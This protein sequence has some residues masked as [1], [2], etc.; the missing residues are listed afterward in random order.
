MDPSTGQKSDTGGI[1]TVLQERSTSLTSK[2]T[3][4]NDEIKQATGFKKLA[5]EANVAQ[6][7]GFFQPYSTPSVSKLASSSLKK[8]F[9]TT[10]AFDNNKGKVF[11]LTAKKATANALTE[12]YKKLV[13][14]ESGSDFL[15]DVTESQQ[16]NRNADAITMIFPSNYF[17]EV[18]KHAFSKGEKD[19]SP[20]YSYITGVAYTEKYTDSIIVVLRKLVY[21]DKATSGDVTDASELITQE[22]NA[23]TDSET[24]PLLLFD[25]DLKGSD[26]ALL[27]SIQSMM[28]YRKVESADNTFAKSIVH[29]ISMGDYKLVLS[30]SYELQNLIKSATP[31]S[32][33]GEYTYSDLVN[34]YKLSAGSS[35]TSDHPSYDS[36]YTSENFSKN[37]VN[38]D[39]SVIQTVRLETRF[40]GSE[41]VLKGN[42]VNQFDKNGVEKSQ[43]L[44]L[45]LDAKSSDGKRSK[46]KV[47]RLADSHDPTGDFEFTE[48][49]TGNKKKMGDFLK[50]DK[51]AE[52]SKTQML[53]PFQ[54]MLKPFQQMLKPFQQMLKPFQQM[55]KPF[56]QMLK[57][58]QQMLKSFQ[59]MLK[60]FQQMLK[61]FQQM[62]KP[63]QQM[64]KP[65]RH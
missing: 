24:E 17:F 47:N 45:E 5:T 56:Q 31:P 22:D 11:K 50:M 10:S 26:G 29:V 33:A 8:I 49:T 39:K 44:K 36:I 12:G 6:G 62:L 32:G 1:T 21:L 27:F 25:A 42:I 52:L 51:V 18:G 19:A 61:S 54:Q 65:F 35:H 9:A 53:K 57:P 16:A 59:Q 55:L 3:T 46:S 37:K 4:A 43:D 63:F 13:Y 28:I 34:V 40:G 30:S 23:H 38:A 48:E 60:S 15:T 58:F 20:E 64:L 7:Q 41:V 2:I 14:P